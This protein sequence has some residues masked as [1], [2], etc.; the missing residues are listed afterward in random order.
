MDLLVSDAWITVGIGFDSSGYYGYDASIVFPFV[1]ITHD[2]H[3]L[4]GN[5]SLSQVCSTP[6]ITVNVYDG[7]TFSGGGAPYSG[8]IG[9]LT[10]SD[11]QF[12][13]A[14]SY[15]WHPFG[16]GSFGA[17]ITG[18][19]DVAAAGTYSFTLDSDD[20]S[21][22][23]I[24]GLLVVDDG[25]AH[26]P[27]IGTG[28]ATL[29]AGTHSFEVQF[30]ECCG[31]PSGVDLT[32]P[33][34][35]T[36]GCPPDCAITCTDV[37]AS[38]DPG[39]CSAVVNYPAPTTTGDCTGWNSFCVPASGSVFPVGTTVV[40]CLAS[41]SSSGASSSCTFTV[42]VNDTEAPVASCVALAPPNAVKNP[43]RIVS[44]MK[45][46]ASDNCDSDP[47]IYINDSASG[48]VA[49]PFH[50]NDKVVIARGPGLTPSQRPGNA[51]YVA[52]ISLKGDALIWAADAS[53]NASPPVKCK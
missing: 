10:A 25:N 26:P 34:G 12:A 22:L 53:G 45:L 47:K 17:D 43:L 6:L 40:S 8:L 5:W 7:F 11:V 21:L 51:G 44:R 16:L 20:G 14:N 50:N 3:F 52:E 49:G 2:D 18:S 29:T 35:V 24:D 1:A 19:L 27:Q 9:T 37:T 48:F 41:N 30:F 38:N 32:L 36:Y 31:G 23:F 28:S 15:N 4:I 42:T 46:V 33:A 39:Q 13:T